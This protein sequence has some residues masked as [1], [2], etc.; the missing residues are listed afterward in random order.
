MGTLPHHLL[1]P[2]PGVSAQLSEATPWPLLDP[3]GPYF[4]CIDR[5]RQRKPTRISRLVSCTATGTSLEAGT[6]APARAQ[7]L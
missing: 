6:I 4:I 2:R 5:Y 1:T 7:I 3:K